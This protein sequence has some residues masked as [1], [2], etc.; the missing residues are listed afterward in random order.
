[1]TVDDFVDEMLSSSP[2]SPPIRH[3]TRGLTLYPKPQRRQELSMDIGIG[4]PNNIVDVPGSLMVEWARRAEQRGFDCVTTIDRL[5]YPSI[6]SVIALALAAGATNELV[7]VTNIL[8]APLYPPAILAKQLA[9]LTL[10]AGERVVIGIAVGARDDDYIA[11][12]VEFH[13]R[14]RLLD[15]QVATMR[16]AWSGKPLVGDTPISPQPVH[17]PLLFG[18]RGKATLRRATTVGAG[19]VAGALRDYKGQAEFLDRVR[20]G[21]REAGRSGEPTNHASVNF[22]I[23]GDEVADTGRR[24]LAHYYGFKPEYAKLNVDDI[25]TTP[26]DARDTV[27]VY[28]ELG[29]DR[30]LFHPAVASLE[31]VDRLADAVL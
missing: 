20:R 3:S 7:L 27:R 12:G 4:L 26:Q 22:A 25:V 29:F 21:W 31:Q 17:I 2:P 30:L 13:E 18:G 28:R 5:I 24:H 9:S 19:W 16:E 23:G 1:M 8:L 15:H 6:D 14:G 11:A 10:A